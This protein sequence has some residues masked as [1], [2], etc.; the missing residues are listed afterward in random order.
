L[1]S[2]WRVYCDEFVLATRS[3][4]AADRFVPCIEVPRGTQN[5]SALA[6]PMTRF[7]TKYQAVGCPLFQVELALGK[8]RLSSGGLL[9]V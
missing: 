2:N 8:K 9:I 6:E 7:E 5:Y 1:R 3:V 4:A